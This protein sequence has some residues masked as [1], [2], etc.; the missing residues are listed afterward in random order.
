MYIIA[1][2]GNPGEK[3]KDSR[4]SAGRIILELYSK[5]L[6]L[7]PF[8]FDKKT[9]SLIAEIKKKAVLIIPETFMNNSGTAIKKLITSKIKAKNLIVIHDDLDLPLGKF[10]ISFNRGTA[11]H[12]G[13]ESII[14]NIKTNEFIR[15]RVGVSPATPGGKIKKPES[16]KIIDFII[17]DFKK[18][19]LLKLK[20]ISKDIF[21]ALELI[22][23]GN[24]DKAMNCF[25]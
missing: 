22:I 16:K 1:G 5:D 18:E 12:K 15:I 8:N 2:L 9:N 3:Y 13:I 14:K 4:H 24:L 6:K 20:K 11:G 17:S 19:E 23:K 25:N 21:E 7:S 10:K